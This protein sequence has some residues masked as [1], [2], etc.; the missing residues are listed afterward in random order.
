MNRVTKAD[1]R[2]AFTRC[3]EDMRMFDTEL[4]ADADAV[5]LQELLND[6]IGA[7]STLPQEYLDQ[8]LR[9]C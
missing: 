1:V 9:V 3:R 2:G 4:R 5:L 6:A 7:L 8:N